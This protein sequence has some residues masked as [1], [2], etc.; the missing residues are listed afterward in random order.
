MNILFLGGDARQ[1]YACEYLIGRR[2]NS[3][4]YTN[5]VLDNDMRKRISGADAIVL[6]LPC[7]IDDRYINM[8]RGSERISVADVAANSSDKCLILGGKIPKSVAAELDLLG[9]R[10][11]DYYGVEEFQIKNAL[12]SAEGAVYYA[13]QSFNSSLHGAKIG[14]FG[15]GRIGKMLAYI[16]RSV[17]AHISVFARKETDI[18]LIDILG[19]HG[20]D[21]KSEE[22]LHSVGEQD[23]IFNT[24]PYNII[25]EKLIGTLRSDT[26][27]VDLA[28]APF[29][30]SDELLE[31]YPLNYHRELGIPGRYAP[32]AAG[33]ILAQVV[34][35]IIAWEG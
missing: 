19:M 27:L 32:R 2:I 17:G 10:Y 7:C 20:V 11:V 6:P 14:I 25:T 13:K 12:L 18:S 3:E 21:I 30:I 31:R 33:E 15:F 9:K 16:L 34:L 23:I 29:G 8:T 28:S 26:V 24:V 35:N 4:V 5:F 22:F 1:E